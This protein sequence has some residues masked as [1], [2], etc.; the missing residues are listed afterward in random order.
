VS[1]E[2][3]EH[4]RTVRLL[5]FLHKRGSV[6]ISHIRW[7]LKGGQKTIYGIIKRLKQ[8][9]LIQEETEQEFP[10]RRV[11]KLT[12]KGVQIATKLEEIQALLEV[13]NNSESNQAQS[14]T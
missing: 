1:I 5:I 10:W 11:I 3:L 8:T 4:A 14:S 7:Q 2:V 13:K 9:T 6:P 12:E